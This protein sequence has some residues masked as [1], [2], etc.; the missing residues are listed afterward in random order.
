MILIIL[1]HEQRFTPSFS[2]KLWLQSDMFHPCMLP[3]GPI[4]YHL[5]MFPTLEYSIE[6][7]GIL[8]R[9]GIQPGKVLN[10]PWNRVNRYDSMAI[11]Y[12]DL[13]SLDPL[14]NTETI[15]SV[16]RDPLSMLHELLLRHDDKELDHKSCLR[17]KYPV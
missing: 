15:L 10:H 1:L 5:A 16:S 3:L 8:V 12:E 17:V 2:M 13:Y 14:K 11:L 7:D 4:S 6:G 9:E